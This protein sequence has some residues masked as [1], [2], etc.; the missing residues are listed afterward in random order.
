MVLSLI[1]L[2]L[3]YYLTLYVREAES[4]AAELSRR[5]KAKFGI[6]PQLTIKYKG[7]ASRLIAQPTSHHDLTNRPQIVLYPCQID[8]RASSA[9]YDRIL[10]GSPRR[11]IS[12]RDSTVFRQ[13]AKSRK[14]AYLE[15]QTAES[16]TASVGRSKTKDGQLRSFRR[17][18][19]LNVAF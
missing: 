3:I 2:S 13:L 12:R 19:I 7:Q 5:F 4:C 9:H 10:L 6:T 18:Q 15:R 1:Q 8:S 17:I 14:A 16:L 11:I